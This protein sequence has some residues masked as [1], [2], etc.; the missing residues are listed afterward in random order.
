MPTISRFFGI[1][2]FMNYNDHQPPHF[3]ARYSE[4]EI[5]V[6]IESGSIQGTISPR[7]KRMIMEWREQHLEELRRDWELAR[8]RK[9]LEQIS[10][11][12]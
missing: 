4:Q 12:V 5:T 6:E 9:P 8:Q 3:H 1:V 11:L 10:P 7:A 2:V